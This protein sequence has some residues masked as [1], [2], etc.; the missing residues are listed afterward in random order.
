MTFT[1]I[2]KHSLFGRGTFTF[3]EMSNTFE[4]R[5][6][7]RDPRLGAGNVAA[8]HILLVLL[9]LLLLLIR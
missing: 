2:F 6:D 3:S 5:I 1:T 7:V 4:L 8:L 9:L